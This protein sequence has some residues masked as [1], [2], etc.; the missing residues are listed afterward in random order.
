[1]GVVYSEVP[2][3]EQRFQCVE[4]LLLFQPLN[5]W[6]AKSK[7]VAREPAGLLCA[8]IKLMSVS[9]GTVRSRDREGTFHLN[10]GKFM[11]SF[12]LCASHQLVYSREQIS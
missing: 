2:N 6:K 10:T 12:R 11:V 9:P 7:E 3:H 5:Y 4:S 1:M 8:G